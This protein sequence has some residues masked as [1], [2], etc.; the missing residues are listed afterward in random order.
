MLNDFPSFLSVFVCNAFW[1]A[2]FF[3]CLKVSKYKFCFNNPFVADGINRS[4]GVNN[5]GV[6]KK[7]EDVH[8]NIYLPDMGKEFVPQAFSFMGAGYKSRYI[9]EFYRCGNDRRYDACFVFD[10][11]NKCIEPGIGDRDDTDIRFNRSKRIIS[12]Q[13]SLFFKKRIKKCRLPRV[14]KPDDTY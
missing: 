7:S 1:F 11:R 13:S 5:I 4:F 10:D 3:K 2:L 6:F 9:N 12:R 8:D 14:R